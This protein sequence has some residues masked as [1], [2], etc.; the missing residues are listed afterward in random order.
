MLFRSI[1]GGV[2]WRTLDRVTRVDDIA[3]GKAAPGSSVPSIYLSGQVD[4]RYG[5]WRSV[6][7]AQGWQRVADFPM[8]RLDQVTVIEGDKD[9]FGRVYV[10]YEGS[11]WL[12]GEPAR[13]PGAGYHQGDDRSCF[14]V[15]KRQ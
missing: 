2:H 14:P 13:C 3:F 9:V 5:I 10:G 7:D 6:D 15:E 4:G 1:D 11:G 12:Y 8:G